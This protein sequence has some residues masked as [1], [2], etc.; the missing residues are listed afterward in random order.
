M[1]LAM[2]IKLLPQGV[3]K[4]TWH[5]SKVYKFLI[6]VLMS[7]LFPIKARNSV[8]SNSDPCQHIPAGGVTM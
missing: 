8:C 7:I 4:R 5:E 1:I 2:A 6:H 3:H